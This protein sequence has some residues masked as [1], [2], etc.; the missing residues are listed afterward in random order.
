ME[1]NFYK[2]QNWTLDEE[3]EVLDKFKLNK[4]EVF[5]VSYK[6]KIKS[7]G[8]FCQ[9]EIT[10]FNQGTIISPYPDF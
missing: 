8:I 2:D 1:V 10:G 9:G 5:P 4:E 6:A 3:R 7:N